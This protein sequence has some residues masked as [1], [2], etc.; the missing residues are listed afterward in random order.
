MANG[1]TLEQ[2]YRKLLRGRSK[3]ADSLPGDPQQQE[4]LTRGEDGPSPSGLLLGDDA[5][6]LAPS[7]IATASQYFAAASAPLA[8]ELR[9]KGPSPYTAHADNQ[10]AYRG[11]GSYRCGLCRVQGHTSRRCPLMDPDRGLVVSHF[12]ALRRARGGR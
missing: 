4:S 11:R 7:Q 5:P 2:Q 1:I 12:E 9:K 3:E 10:A 6:T 8:A